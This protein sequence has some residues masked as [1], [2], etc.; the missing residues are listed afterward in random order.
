METRKPDGVKRQ[1]ITSSRLVRAA[2]RV[3]AQLR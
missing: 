1:S 3:F 2:A